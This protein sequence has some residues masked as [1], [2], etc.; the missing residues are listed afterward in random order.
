MPRVPD[1]IVP[2]TPP[3][4]AD[5]RRR[6]R[7]LWRWFDP[8]F[9]GLE[10]VDPAM[11][12]LFVGNHTI[13]GI[14]DSPLLVAGLYSRTGVY[15]RSLGDEYHYE[16]PVWGDLL[17][18]YGTVPGS[19]ENCARLMAA[20]QHVLVFPGGA[21]EVAKRRGEENRLTWKNRTGFAHM[22]IRFQY[23]ILP[24]ASLGADDMYSILYDADDFQ[25]SALGRRLLANDKVAKLLRDGDLFMPLVRGLGPTLLPRPERFYFMFGKPIPT[26]EFAGQENSKAA[27]WELRERVADAIEGMIEQLKAIRAADRPPLLRRLLTKR[28]KA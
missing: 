16:I 3:P 8:Q 13:F 11:P 14:I 4:P 27:Q 5:V 18:R 17:L 21:R 1:D 9:H 7:A 22:A 23:P 10:N 15:P 6:V 28:R 2:F 24:F 20:G 12:S 26:T 19:R 25:A